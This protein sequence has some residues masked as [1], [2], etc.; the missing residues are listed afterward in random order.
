LKLPPAPFTINPTACDFPRSYAALT[1]TSLPPHLN[2]LSDSF[3]A[4]AALSHANL[5]IP[6]ARVRAVDNMS[7]AAMLLPMQQRRLVVPDEK[8][9]TRPPLSSTSEAP[10]STKLK[11]PPCTAALCALLNHSVQDYSRIRTGPVTTETH[12]LSK[13]HDVFEDMQVAAFR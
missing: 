2:F 11:V 3:D 12:A 9:P 7:K 1:L 13:F 6:V 5:P 4:A 8:L 10:K